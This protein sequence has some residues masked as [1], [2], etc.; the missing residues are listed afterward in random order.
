[1]SLDTHNRTK[2]KT[3]YAILTHN[4]RENKGVVSK[5]TFYDFWCEANYLCR[6][7]DESFPDNYDDHE[8]MKSFWKQYPYYFIDHLPINLVAQLLSKHFNYID[9]LN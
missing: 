2:L 8:A 5:Q 4:F 9:T 7:L 1:M 6:E 3:F